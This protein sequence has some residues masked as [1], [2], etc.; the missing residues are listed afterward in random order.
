[1]QNIQS[2]LT[3]GGLVLL[4]LT[5]LRFNTAILETS[6]ADVESKVYLTAFSLADD[7]IEEIKTKSF[8]E[9]TIDF[10]TINKSALT[11]ANTLAPESGETY[12]NFDDI[13]DFNNYTN[14][15][16]APHA[17]G[18][19][20]TCQVKYVNENDQDSESSVQTFYK[21]VTVTVTSPYMR[22]PVALSFIFTLK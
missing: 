2:Y 7:L 3:M 13:D 20:I 14:L 15:I 11:A 16:D 9:K 19:N 12:S 6:T 4:S 5:S 17:E 18:Y 10:P 1:M 8:D 22:T 21:K